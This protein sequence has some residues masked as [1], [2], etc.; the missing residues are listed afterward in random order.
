MRLQSLLPAT[1]WGPRDIV[2]A[3]LAAIGVLLALGLAIAIANGGGDAESPLD[4]E[5]LG[6]SLTLAS[7]I[8]QGGVLLGAAAAFSLAKHNAGLWHLGFVWPR[9][10]KAYGYALLLWLCALG[11]AVVYGLVVDAAGIEW[12]KPPDNATEVLEMSGGVW[13][14]V[15]LAGIWAPLNEEIFFRAFVLGGLAR[16][17]SPL[18]A[19]ALSSAVFALFHVEPGLYFPTFVLGVAM[20]LS[21]V[22]SGSIVPSI[23][24]HALHNTAGILIARYAPD[25]GF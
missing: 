9:S 6:V 22:K 5:V 12:L 3:L 10:G 4:G 15:L 18:T 16:R 24:I 20:A 19:A 13:G 17:Y 7:I 8:F 21:Y 11:T 1:P 25:S 23:G 14:A 2:W